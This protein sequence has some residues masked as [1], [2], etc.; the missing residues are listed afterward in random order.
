MTF[1]LVFGVALFAAVLISARA[2]CG[3]LSTAVLF[4]VVGLAVGATNVVSAPD[5]H[6]VERV[7]ELA[8]VATLFT[9]GGKMNLRSLRA[10]FRLPGRALLIGLPINLVVA[11]VFAR[12]LLPLSWGAA[13]LVG[14]V[15]SPTDPVF[16]SSLVGSER[17]PAKLR[18]L[19]NIESGLNDGLAVPIVVSLLGVLGEEAPSVGVL[20]GRVVLGVVIGAGVPLA[21]VWLYRRPFFG[22]S[23][24]YKP[25]FA[26]AVVVVAWALSVKVSANE[27]LAA[28]VAGVVL[29]S[30]SDRARDH[31]QRPGELVSEVSKLAALLLFGALVSHESMRDIGLAGVVFAIASLFVARPLS[32]MLALLRSD[33]P[34]RE[35]GVAAW[36][37]PRGFASV[38]FALL[39]HGSK[40]PGE[41]IVFHATAFVVIASILLHATTDTV[42]AKW[43]ATG[44]ADRRDAH[45]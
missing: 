35:R 14:A 10:S 21:A 31:W 28:F 17:V 11:A 23:D 37:G 13:F 32:M 2:A 18:G 36:F 41:R 8:L 43:L 20:L 29:S 45:A 25:V 9:D 24:A 7:A 26:L 4:L 39:V 5:E 16:A 27:F 38:V 42:V 12:L 33:L 15:L 44:D 6:T 40:I 34:V 22:A 30:V 1:A 3:L 19:L